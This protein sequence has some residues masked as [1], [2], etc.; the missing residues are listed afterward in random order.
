[1]Y[2]KMVEMHL[3][4]EM[5]GEYDAFWFDLTVMEMESQLIM[6]QDST[7]GLLRFVVTSLLSK[8]YILGLTLSL[9]F[10]NMPYLK[11]F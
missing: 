11:W 9:H 7:N 6:L 2:I 1:M 10:H 3:F 8:S 5:C 4:I